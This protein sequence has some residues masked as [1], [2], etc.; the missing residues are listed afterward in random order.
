MGK[1]AAWLLEA[2]L[3]VAGLRGASESELDAV[4]AAVLET[5][6][7]VPA[8]LAPLARI[9]APGIGRATLLRLYSGDRGRGL[10]EPDTL[11]EAD[12]REFEG[13]LRPIEVER[14]RAAIAA[15]RG[16]TLRRRHHAHQSRAQQVAL[17]ERL[18]DDLYTA[19]G[20]GL[21]QAVSD[22]LASAG[23]SVTRIKRQ[24]HGEEDLQISHQGGVIVASVTASHDSAKHVSWNKAREVLGTGAGM[25][26]INYVCF[27]R[28]GFHSLAERRVREI[29]R[30]TG[31]RRLL[32][33]PIDVLAEGVVRCREGRLESE[34]LGAVF[35]R[36]RGLLT[37]GGLPTADRSGDG[38]GE[39]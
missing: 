14:L 7:G 16:E 36:S 12:A 1:T 27:G 8:D 11:L 39:L 29:S 6:Y 38:A 2:V 15:E 19:N 23:L 37:I 34:A 25:N 18:I 26:P 13:L 20:A 24:P 28:P 32:L 30:E 5:R 21:E 10:Y 17:D 4:R 35:A 3:Q 22:A 31:T 9:R 33:V